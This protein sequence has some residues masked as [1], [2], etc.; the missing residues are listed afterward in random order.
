MGPHEMGL[1]FQGMPNRI[2]RVLRG[3]I[4]R[5]PRRKQNAVCPQSPEP[6]R[7]GCMCQAPLS[8][9]LREQVAGRVPLR[10]PTLRRRHRHGKRRRQVRGVRQRRTFVGKVKCF[11]GSSL[12]VTTTAAFGRTA[13]ALS[14]YVLRREGVW[15]LASSSVF[16]EA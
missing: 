10:L 4:L 15:I 9:R 5:Y 11:N 7:D 16:V 3:T 14:H 8:L 6:R 12:R 1:S 13:A 2:R